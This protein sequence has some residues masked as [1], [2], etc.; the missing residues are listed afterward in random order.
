MRRH[1]FIAPVGV[2]LL[3]LGAAAAGMNSIPVAAADPVKTVP[4]TVM[5]SPYAN[6]R[7]DAQ[8][9]IVGQ[10]ARDAVYTVACYEIGPDQVEGW[11]GSSPYWDKVTDA[12]GAEVG[13]IADVWLNTGGDITTQVSEC[14]AAGADNHTNMIMPKSTYNTPHHGG[15]LFWVQRGSGLAY[16]KGRCTT[17]FAV[18]GADNRSY[19]LTAGHCVLSGIGDKVYAKEGGWFNWFLDES[20]EFGSFTAKDSD[21]DTALV[22]ALSSPQIADGPTD[23]R[24]TKHVA[25]VA[26]DLHL[27]QTLCVSGAVSGAHCALEIVKFN[28]DPELEGVKFKGMIKVKVPVGVSAACKGDSGGPAFVLDPVQPQLVLAVGTITGGAHYGGKAACDASTADDPQYLYISPIQPALDRW[29]L[30]LKTTGWNTAPVPGTPTL[31]TVALPNTRT[32]PAA[33]L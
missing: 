7:D 19:L 22:E 27:G 9:A 3:M 32:R 17:G 33:K 31:T 24:F 1:R 13:F 4:A 12:S 15:Q 2:G 14:P 18:S 30:S 28:D 16:E 21:T 25:G 26:R 23:S 6:I 29:K 11:G 8:G 5:A 20:S 10:A